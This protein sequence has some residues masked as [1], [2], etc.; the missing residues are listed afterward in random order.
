MTRQ[1]SEVS[2]N[3]L[4]LIRC[5]G[6]VAVVGAAASC[7]A[8]ASFSE[9]FEG[10]D[11]GT[12]SA[13]GPPMLVSR[14]WVF[15]NQS[16]PAGSGFSPYWTPFPAWGQ[17]GSGLGHGGFATWQDTSSKI[18]AWMILPQV[19]GQIAG[20]PLRLW[21]SA[22]TNAFGMNNSILEIRYSPSGGTST[23]SNEND[24]GNFTQVL[25]TIPGAN[26]HPWTERIVTLP[27][28]GR[29]AV[30]YILPPAPTNFDFTGTFVID[31][32]RVGVLPVNYPIPSP[33]QTVHWTT[34]MSP[35][36]I[37]Y[38][39]T[40]PAGGT[41]I[42]DPG[43]EVRIASTEKLH[44]NG[45]LD[46]REGTRF[47]V[48]IDAQLNI[49]GEAMFN[50]TAASRVNL[51]GGAAW[52]GGDYGYQVKHT[53]RAVLNHV[54][55]DGMMK[56]A[57]YIYLTGGG[58]I[59]ASD[60]RV[61][62]TD[63][64]FYID[65]GTL[66]LRDSSFTTGMLR[67]VDSYLLADHVTLNNAQLD[68]SRYNAGQTIYLDNFTAT[69]VVNDSPF[70]LGGF[71][72]FFGTHNTISGN[73]YPVHLNGGGIAPGSTLPLT[74]NTSS[75]IHG[76]IGTLGG[77]GTFPNLGLE[78]RIDYPGDN[79]TELGGILTIE[80]GV[81]INFDWGAYLWAT[82]GSNIIARGT[83][84]QPITFKRLSPGLIWQTV[85]FSVNFNRPHLEYCIFDG[86]DRAL[87]ADETVVRARDCEFRNNNTGF[88]GVN[89]LYAE[90]R[91]SRFLNNGVGLQA[92]SNAGFVANG[93][94]MPNLFQGNSLAAENQSLTSTE[95]ATGNYWGS[96]TGPTAANNPGGNGDP[97]GPYITFA[98]FRTTPPDF[99]DTAPAVRLLPTSFLNEHNR[100]IL[101]TW[102]AS[103]N[104]AIVSQRIEWAPHDE[105]LP[106][107]SV[108]VPN[109]PASARSWE[110][111]IPEYGFSNCI[112]PAVLRVVAVDDAGQEGF[113][114]TM[115]GLPRD[116]DPPAPVPYPITQTLRPGQTIDVCVNGNYFDATLFLDG[117]RWSFSLG[118]TTTNCLSGGAH[119]PPVSTDLA[120]IG[121][122]L[123]NSW[124]FTPYF[125][126]RPD[127]AIGDAP[128][129]VTMFSPTAG[130]A[131][132]GGSI[133][134][135]SWAATDDEGVRSFDIHASYDGGRTWHTIAKD[136][137]GT[138]TAFNWQLPPST[139]I[140]DVRV[141]V[142]VRDL[143]F[144]NSS[145]GGDRALSITPGSGPTPCY[146]NCDGS[147]TAPLLTANDFQ[148]FL[149]KFASGDTYA[150]CDQSTAAPV[151]T[152]NDFQCFL[153]R[154]AAGC[155]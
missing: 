122:R 14:G 33:G 50:G 109:I 120:R 89:Y 13:G 145:S 113:D 37:G 2:V 46:A 3:Q 139:G 136:L 35:I 11:D 142:M 124:A 34:A 127:P 55:L 105:C 79:F 96:P 111:T 92:A 123:G 44:V 86:G 103:D 126:I 60:V 93:G 19:P 27:G 48:P 58:R 41:V 146:A 97:I 64:G 84:A 7:F 30:R 65:R 12:A 42:V 137:P 75:M 106:G 39:T 8:Q 18:S 118:G 129:V 23:G 31:S 38:E 88:R 40:I 87:V 131:L 66:A 16:R 155:S 57:T 148:C 78:Y 107:L 59:I 94:T 45:T 73:M 121:I 133:V 29:A 141:R 70:L 63:C 5:L 56:T 72:H 90:V 49:V 132:A 69:G 117:D 67:L 112:D 104:Q 125:S 4:C 54:D 74:G 47:T 138:A 91:K 80:P 108:L 149:N 83:Q 10:L 130:Q 102:T 9:S 134:P 77:R 153:N 28:A 150:N 26:G 71:D 36:V 43:V 81:T 135:I 140:P 76:G 144:Q 95:S 21:T 51:G 25:M 15:R 110:V 53:G 24:V 98:P 62:Q 6:A 114:E 20:D 143:R 128:P 147:T 100:K 85:D 152:A 68:S 61:T 32:V 82:Y 99:T 22:P 17:S 154:F 52:F 1:F 101:L 115:Y 116:A 151:L 119:M